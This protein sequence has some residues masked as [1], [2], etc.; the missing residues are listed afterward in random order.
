MQDATARY[1]AAIR[2]RFTLQGL[3]SYQRGSKRRQCAEPGTPP[4]NRES[5][6]KSQSRLARVAGGVLPKVAAQS[7]DSEHEQQKP[8]LS[9]RV[10]NF[11]SQGCASVF[12]CVCV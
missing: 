3:T 6:N 5:W 12:V 8:W 9:L 11:M 1:L 2:L 10:A 7:F 4:R